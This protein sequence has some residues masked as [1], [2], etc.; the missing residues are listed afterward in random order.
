MRVQSGKPSTLFADVTY[1]RSDR[2]VNG[3]NGTGARQ[4]AVDGDNVFALLG[5]DTRL[6]TLSMFAYLVDQDE[7]AV[8]GYRLS[9]QI[10]NLRF[11][12]VA[13]LARA[14]KIG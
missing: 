5:A 6:G 7:A 10:Y 11:A 4:Q 2:T 3:I 12:G 14:V 13:S 8:Q 9:S 1:A